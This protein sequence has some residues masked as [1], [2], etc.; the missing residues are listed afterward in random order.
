MRTPR[1]LLVLALA[2]ALGLAAA[3]TAGA[4]RG[5]VTP[6]A[7]KAQ[8]NALCVQAKKRIAGLPKSTTASPAQIG[9]ALAKALDALDPLLPQFQKLSP[10]AA[11]KTLHDKTVASLGDALKLGHGIAAAVTRGSNMQTA[12]AKVQGP[13]LAAASGIQTGFKALGLVTCESVLGA[14]IGGA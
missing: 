3:S 10:P 14:A 13:F 6:A 2:L 9:K 4:A 5:S 11:Q 7:Y 1:L 8:A 12:L